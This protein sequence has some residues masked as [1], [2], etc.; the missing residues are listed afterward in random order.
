MTQTFIFTP[1]NRFM[2]IKA[3]IDGKLSKN[4]YKIYYDCNKYYLVSLAENLCFCKDFEDNKSCE[5]LQVLKEI[6]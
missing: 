5:H 2:I 4:F 6:L 1:D 3:T